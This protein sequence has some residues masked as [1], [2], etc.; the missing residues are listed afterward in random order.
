MGIRGTPVAKE[1]A[2]MVLQDDEFGTIVEA[3]A[4]GRAIYENIRKFIVYLLSC[5]ISEILIV[6]IATIAGAPLPLLP[7]QILFLNLVTDIFPALALG[8][9]EGSPALMKKRPRPF[10]EPLLTRSH[11]IR[12]VLHG[13]VIAVSVLVAMAIAITQLDAST[14]RAV[15]I[16]FCTLTLAQVWHVFNMRDNIRNPFVN[17]VTRNV[18]IWLAIV[19]CVM[20]L[21]AAVYLPLLADVL[22][23]SHPGTD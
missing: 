16:S 1:A 23:L 19:T 6:G 10:A 2:A 20:L 5:N 15:T 9:G 13:F 18:W 12:I 14:E 3:V 8:V 7:L 21:L 22:K 11:W 17:E 4:Q